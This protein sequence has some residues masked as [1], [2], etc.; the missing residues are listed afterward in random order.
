[1]NDKLIKVIFELRDDSN[2]ARSVRKTVRALLTEYNIIPENIADIETI[3]GELCSNVEL[4]GRS[5]SGI[6]RLDVSVYHQCVTLKVVDFGSGFD[7][8]RV[9]DPMPLA[10]VDLIEPVDGERYGG[11]GIPT[12]KALSGILVYAPT[13][14]HGTTVWVRKPVTDR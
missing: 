1:M 4:H 6:Y 11:W 13:H 10:D 2:G 7:F 12:I 5:E 3:I 14:P 9:S 8:T